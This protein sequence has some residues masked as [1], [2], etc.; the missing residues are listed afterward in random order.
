MH[1]GMGDEARI[2]AT[3]SKPADSEQN[4]ICLCIIKTGTMP[5]SQEVEKND[6]H[7]PFCFDWGQIFM[8]R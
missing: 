2:G 3:R 1:G 5:T 7:G 6:V 4:C 8:T